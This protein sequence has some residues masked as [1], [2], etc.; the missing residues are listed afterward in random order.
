MANPIIGETGSRYLPFKNTTES[1]GMIGVL[2]V[3]SLKNGKWSETSKNKKISFYFLPGD[4]LERK[5]R[6]AD[7]NV[8][9][10]F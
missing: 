7:F 4:G 5:Y 10:F 2:W 3:G 1:Q 6:S 8:F 9:L